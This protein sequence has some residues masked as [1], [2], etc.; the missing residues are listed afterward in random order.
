MRTQ[1]SETRTMRIGTLFLTDNWPDK[2]IRK[3]LNYIQHLEAEGFDNVW[4]ANLQDLDALTAL[5]LAG[6]ATSSIGLGSAVT[7]I[8]VRHPVAMAQQALTTAIACD[9]RFTLGIGLSHKVVIEDMLGLS[10]QHPAAHMQEYLDILMPLLRGEAV[11]HQGPLYRVDGRLKLGTGRPVPCI[12]GA[13]GP[14]ML[15][16]AGTLADGTVTWMTGPKTLNSHII[17]TITRAAAVAGRPSPRVVAGLPV[18]LCQDVPAARARLNESLKLYGVLP[19]YR[20]MLD[21]EGVAGPGDIALLGDEE[22]LQRQVVALRDMGV[23][24]LNAAV[25]E[26]EPGSQRRTIAFLAKLR[27]WMDA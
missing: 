16:I 12:V 19:S 2:N 8:Q 23:T 20:A 15:K 14:R 17:P 10:Y 13:L 25:L 11:R 18:S 7:P 4:M 9:N 6:P 22:S 5:A 27:A 3:F 26:V 21:R 24:D 1:T